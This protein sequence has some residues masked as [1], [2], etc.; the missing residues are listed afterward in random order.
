MSAGINK[1]KKIK[2]Y[3]TLYIYSDKVSAPADGVRA[4]IPYLF[5]KKNIA[6]LIKEEKNNRSILP[7]M[8]W[9]VASILFFFVF[10]FFFFNNFSKGQSL[11]NSV[12]WK[13]RYDYIS[14]GGDRNCNEKVFLENFSK[15][16]TSYKIIEGEKRFTVELTNEYNEQKKA[17]DF[18]HS[19]GM[20][21]FVNG[22]YTIIQK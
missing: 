17:N 19:E 4:P 21:I 7:R 1:E 18:I 20:D 3:F 9:C 5:M 8:A 2:L 22:F 13:E 10:F 11:V 6:K 16:Y 12:V 14:C 15:R